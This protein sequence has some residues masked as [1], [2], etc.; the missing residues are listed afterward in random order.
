MKF[1]H[2][3][4]SLTFGQLTSFK[5]TLEN[6]LYREIIQQRERFMYYGPS[7]HSEHISVSNV[8]SRNICKT[9]PRWS[10]PEKNLTFK[11]KCDGFGCLA[12][13]AR[14]VRHC[15]RRRNELLRSWPHK[16]IN[17]WFITIYRWY[18]ENVIWRVYIVTA[19][20]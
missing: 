3:R 12:S 15:R 9:T 1:H 11:S 13:V 4:K 14:S 10:Q 18:R 17:K 5:P 16:I 7:L 6:L 8:D 19:S 2:F 20:V